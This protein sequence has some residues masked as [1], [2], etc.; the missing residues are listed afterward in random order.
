M[1]ARILTIIS[2]FALAGSTIPV[3]PAS[4]ASSQLI[5][6]EEQDGFFYELWDYSIPRENPISMEPKADGCFS[7]SWE[8]KCNSLFTEFKAYQQFEEPL[9][10]SKYGD[11]VRT[12][13]ADFLTDSDAY[14]EYAGTMH[15]EIDSNIIPI[16]Y[17]IIEAYGSANPLRSVF[18][19]STK[20]KLGVISSDGK[21]YDLYQTDEYFSDFSLVPSLISYWSIAQDSLA[22][23]GTENHIS[24]TVTISNHFKAWAGL[25]DI[26]NPL[27]LET[28]GMTV[29]AY[30]SN[31]S[32]N[33]TKNV[34]NTTPAALSLLKAGD[35]DH[36]PSENEKTAVQN[37]N[38]HSDSS[39]EDADTC[40]GDVNA[41]GKVSI[42]D[43]VMLQRYTNE[44]MVELS[45]N[46]RKMADCDHDGQLTAADATLI[47][48][49]IARLTVL[50]PAAK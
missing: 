9:P 31:G 12:Y 32:V 20:H 10:C 48:Q 17:H 39:S 4:A 42:A 16:E 29:N 38:N 15:T 27:I 41:D 40:Y 26:D 23:V 5:S 8:K 24:S 13:E 3:L 2:T 22:E 47:V 45:E 14:L 28:L 25:T 50:N 7:S 36:E 19:G 11:F 43:A 44:E 30:E 35:D 37:G 33:I 6:Q 18:L 49:A 34:E 46:G 1:K 21:N